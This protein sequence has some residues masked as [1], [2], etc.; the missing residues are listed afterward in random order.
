MIQETRDR[1]FVLSRKAEQDWG[2]EY[3]TFEYLQ[4]AIDGHVLVTPSI[5][6][7]K[8]FTAEQ[9]EAGEVDIPAGFYIKKIHDA[10]YRKQYNRYKW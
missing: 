7:A 9:V 10:K 8:K 2:G 3:V 6:Y 4:E 5:R 1:D